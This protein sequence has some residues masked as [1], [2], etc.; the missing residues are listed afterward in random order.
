MVE[1]EE[2]KTIIVTY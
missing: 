1:E 2:C